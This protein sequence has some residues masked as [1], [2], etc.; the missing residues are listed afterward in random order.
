MKI[1][2]LTA[3]LDKGGAETHIFE[4]AQSLTRRS[5]E[6]FVASSGGRIARQLSGAGI[7]HLKIPLNSKN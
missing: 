6:I 3:S 2:M 1:L 5:H 7:P 4:L